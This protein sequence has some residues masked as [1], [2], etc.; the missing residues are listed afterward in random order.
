MSRVN[1]KNIARKKT[2]IK[3]LIFLGFV[4]IVFTSFGLGKELVRRQK[5]NEEIGNVKKEIESME[6]KNKELSQL[7]EYLNTDSFKEIQARQNLGYRKEGESVV[8]IESGDDGL[9]KEN[10]ASF[11]IPINKDESNMKKW[12][13]HFFLSKE[14]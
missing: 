9:N 12:W 6:K 14:T 1:K 4:L 2:T 13:N 5:I 7:I 10:E 8:S 11:E 3:L